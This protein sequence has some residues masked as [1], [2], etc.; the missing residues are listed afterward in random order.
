MMPVVVSISF[1][2]FFIISLGNVLFEAQSYKTYTDTVTIN[3]ITAESVSS[4]TVFI[5]SLGLVLVFSV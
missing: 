5:I 1:I 3:I 4:V 2:L